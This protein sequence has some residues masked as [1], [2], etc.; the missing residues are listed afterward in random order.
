VNKEESYRTVRFD[1][2]SRGKERQIKR[3][4]EPDLTRNPAANKEEWYG[5]I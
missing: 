5:S 3:K 4:V 1:N 2:D